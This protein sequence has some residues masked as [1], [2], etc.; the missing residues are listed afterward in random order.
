MKLKDGLRGTAEEMQH[1]RGVHF[2]AEN[3]TYPQ[4][5]PADSICAHDNIS[6][7]DRIIELPH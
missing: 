7:D 1:N 6:I 4:P 2:T 3:W 5:P